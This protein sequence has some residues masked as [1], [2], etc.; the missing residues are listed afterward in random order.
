MQSY[1]LDSELKLMVSSGVY[2][3]VSTGKISVI[4]CNVL[5]KQLFNFYV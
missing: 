4:E 1:N 3:Q 5:L 2:S